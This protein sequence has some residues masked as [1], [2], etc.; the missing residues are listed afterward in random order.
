MVPL[1]LLAQLKRTRPLLGAM[2]ER[3]EEKE[4]LE[5]SLDEGRLSRESQGGH[6]AS[7]DSGRF[8]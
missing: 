1:G 6:G 2:E 3:M 5:E 8:Y 7:L 4:S